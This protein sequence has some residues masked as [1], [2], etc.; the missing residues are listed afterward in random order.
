M[1]E[2]ERNKIILEQYKIMWSTH[3]AEMARFWQRYSVLV[4][5][6]LL[7][8]GF[9]KLLNFGA[10]DML[11]NVLEAIV[12]FVCSVCAVITVSIV[13]RE[14]KV[15]NLHIHEIMKF[16]KQH[17]GFGILT[18]AVEGSKE[19]LLN[20]KSPRSYSL[21]RVIPFLLAFIFVVFF[22]LKVCELTGSIT[23]EKEEKTKSSCCCNDAR[24][25]KSQKDSSFDN[26][27]IKAI[28]KDQETTS[29]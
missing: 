15:Y 1:S 29:D 10:T 4:S 7:A 12:L 8:I 11:T 20:I 24:N 21:A 13:T 25:N 23:W 27:S 28:I 14:I 17:D 6:Q 5:A 16:E 18:N 26:S 3:N 2:E 22:A 19:L 9:F